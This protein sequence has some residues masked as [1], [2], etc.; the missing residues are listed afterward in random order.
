MASTRRAGGRETTTH[1]QRDARGPARPVQLPRRSPTTTTRNGRTTP[2]PTTGRRQHITRRPRPGRRSATELDAQGRL[3]RAGRGAG[4]RA[5]GDRPRRPR[6]HQRVQRAARVDLRDDDANRLRRARRRGRPA[7]RVRPRRRSTARRARTPERPRVRLRLR[8]R[9]QPRRG[10][11]CPTATRTR[12][13]TR[14]ATGSS[15]SRPPARRP[16]WRSPRRGPHA[17]HDHAPGGRRSTTP[18]TPRAGPTG[19]PTTARGDAS[20]TP[21]T[22]SG[23]ARSAGRRPAAGRTRSSPRRGTPTC[24]KSVAATGLAAGRFDYTYDADLRLSR[25]RSSPAARDREHHRV[26]RDADGLV[27]GSARSR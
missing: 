25:G 23:R 21:A 1:R 19:R 2:A 14:P 26:T 24:P 12:S 17:R 20:R 8:R 7:D 18:A 13:A 10:D 15:A 16:G 6:A 27:T 5:A 9:R 22:R 11:G 4:A 3:D